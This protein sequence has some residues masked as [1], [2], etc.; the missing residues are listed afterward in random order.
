MAVNSFEQLIQG[1]S[2]RL[3]KAFLDAVYQLRN[4]AQLENIARR[5][6]AN[7]IEGAV[8]AA[9]LNPVAFRQLDVQTS[10]AFESSGNITAKLIPIVADG[11]TGVRQVFRFD[12]ANPDA[13]NWLHEHS[14]QFVTQILDDQRNMIREFLAQAITDGV[15]P[16]STALKLVGI[17]NKATGK[18]EGGIIGLTTSQM[19]WVRNYEAE[20]RAGSLGALTRQLRDRRFDP[21]VR[22]AAASGEPISDSTI[23]AMV[24]A[25]SNRALQM[26]GE[27]IART[28][29]VLALHQAQNQAMQQAID[30]GIIQAQAVSFSWHTA[31]DERVRDS[32]ES[33]DGQRRRLGD[34]FVDGDGNLLEYPGDPSAPAETTINCRCWREPDVDFL[35]GIE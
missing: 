12:M 14:S 23:T 15:N 33:M 2:P 19:Q 5:L 27:A 8:S 25:Y 17:I 22:A 30:S 6:I 31:H 9:G 13:R 18:R 21:S 11:V 34:P 7:D 20:L 26:R 1:W 28:E 4:A 35:A 10:L 29:T 3:R 16:R 24:K 32:H